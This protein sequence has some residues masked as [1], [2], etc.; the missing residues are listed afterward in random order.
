M[1][2]GHGERERERGRPGSKKSQLAAGNKTGYQRLHCSSWQ[3]RSVSSS[4]A[5]LDD[6]TDPSAAQIVFS[7]QRSG[8]MDHPKRQQRTETEAARTHETDHSVTRPSSINRPSSQLR[9]DVMRQPS[10]DL[11]VCLWFLSTTLTK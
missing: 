5:A 1:R 9:E 10:V 2:I 6:P 7:A 3:R 8:T 11:S 4:A